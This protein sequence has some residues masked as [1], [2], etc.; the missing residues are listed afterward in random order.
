MHTAPLPT[1]RMDPPRGVRAIEL[2]AGLVGS[3][4]LWLGVV[5]LVLQ[6]VT[7]Q[8]IDGANGPGWGTVVAH[9]LVGGL[10]EAG[11]GAR[12]KV[13]VPARVAISVLTILAVLA[14]LVISWWR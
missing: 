11:R 2:V 7:P 1:T 6:L 3:G 9:L 12:R 14:V 5:L 10:A 4:M 8:Q 13:P